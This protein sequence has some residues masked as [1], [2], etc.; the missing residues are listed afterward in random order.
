MKWVRTDLWQLYADGA[1]VVI[2]TNSGWTKM[3]MNVMGRGLACQAATIIEERFAGL[4]LPALY[5]GLCRTGQPRVYLRSLDL[6]LVPTKPRVGP[7]HLAWRGKA[8]WTTVEQSLE[9]LK[10]HAAVFDK[11]VAV[12]LLGAGNGGL[13]PE[14]VRVLIEDWLGKQSDVIGVLP[15]KRGR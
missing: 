12:P 3:G 10:T 4:S 6:I 5:G 13:D 2:P 1:T 14:V 9:W 8:V 15:P 11:P 7:P